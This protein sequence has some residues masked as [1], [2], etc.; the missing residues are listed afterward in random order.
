MSRASASRVLAAAVFVALVLIGASPAAAAG[1]GPVS[2][3]ALVGGVSLLGMAEDAAR[4]A[5]AT[6]TTAPTLADL[7]VIADGVTRTLETSGTVI[8]DVEAMLDEAYASTATDP[9]TLKTAYMVDPGA[10]AAVLAPI[11]AVTEVAPVNARHYAIGRTLSVAPSSGGRR[12]DR[13]AAI[14]A[15]SASL[16]VSAGDSGAAQPAITLVIVPVAPAIT[17]ATL[18]RAILISLVQRKLYLYNGAGLETVYR[19]A[20][21]MRRYPTPKG[22]FS[23]IGKKVMPG[24][25][26]P[27]SRWAR[28]MPRY[29]RPGPRNPLGTRAL[30]LSASGI[31]IHGTPQ[32]SSIGRAASHGCVRML[33]KNIEQMYPLVPVGTKVFIVN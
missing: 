17:E 3:P 9:F 30:Y 26:N 19:C 6:N 5:I 29:I 18:G 24:W 32:A 20:I 15:I 4:A 2:A 7:D 1:R 16:L 14:T 11:A 28:G 13:A 33:R 25:T 21:G 8:V 10:V 22:V 27:G 12:L 23:V 31:R